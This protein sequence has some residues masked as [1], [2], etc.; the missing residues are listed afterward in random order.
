VLDIIPA[1]RP[2]GVTLSTEDG[3]DVQT[4]AERW[5]A[6]TDHTFLSLVSVLIWY[7]P[8]SSWH[9]FTA[10]VSQWE[11][12]SVSFL[13]QM[14][15]DSG[16][17]DGR[18]RWCKSVWFLA[19]IDDKFWLLT[20][21]H[22]WPIAVE[23]NPVATDWDCFKD[24]EQLNDRGSK[25]I[26]LGELDTTDVSKWTA[27]GDTGNNL[28]SLSNLKDADSS[29]TWVEVSGS[30]FDVTSLESPV[31]N[32]SLSRLTRAISELEI[33]LLPVGDFTFSVETLSEL[34]SAFN[35]AKREH[36][37]CP[38]LAFIEG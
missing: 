9:G 29:R 2:L 32:H 5:F 22:L 1:A 28:L 24:G 26:L 30:E 14:V 6:V 38:E 36:S 20:N 11:G 17:G 33:S 13:M 16:A 15:D 12:E 3:R 25:C 7:L 10:G 4:N 18:L 23:T 35:F 19:A 8:C 31:R 21:L 34:K 27:L 37:E